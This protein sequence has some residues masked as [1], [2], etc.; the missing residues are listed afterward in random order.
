MFSQAPQN[1]PAPGTVRSSRRRQRPSNEGSISQPKAKRQRSALSE[2]TFV[3]PDADASQEMEEVKNHRT[4]TQTRQ[5]RPKEIAG[6]PREI[7]VR[8]RKLRSGDGGNKGDG[9]VVLVGQS[10]DYS[11]GA[12]LICV[13]RRLQTRLTLS[14]SFL[15][16]QTDSVAMLQVSSARQH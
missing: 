2:K 15:L 8:G 6:P 16:F 7:A 9:S 5:D 1:V 3:P 14:A 11:G 10:S 13:L 12:L 4:P